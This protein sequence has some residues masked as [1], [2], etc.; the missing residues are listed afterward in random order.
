MNTNTPE[1]PKPCTCL[2]DTNAKLKPDG[3]K[4]DDRLQAL[5]MTGKSLT[6]GWLLPVTKLDGKRRKR[7]D[8]AGVW[9][10]FCPFCGTKL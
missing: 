7:T 8:P 4:I 3:L 5:R 10:E 9:M 2:A 1:A 6:H